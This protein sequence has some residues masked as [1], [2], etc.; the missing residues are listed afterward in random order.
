MVMIPKFLQK[1]VVIQSHTILTILLTLVAHF[2]ALSPAYSA[3]SCHHLFDKEPESASVHISSGMG[4]GVREINQTRSVESGASLIWLQKVSDWTAAWD[5]ADISGDSRWGYRFLGAKA[6]MFGF[7][8]RV[9]SHEEHYS[10]PTIA[11][12]NWAIEHFN[13]SHPDNAIPLRLKSVTQLSSTKDFLSDFTDGLI[14]VGTSIARTYLHD[15]NYHYIVA[16][17][18][19]PKLIE[20]W[21]RRAK[22]VLDVVD[23]VSD[24]FQTSPV[25]IQNLPHILAQMAARVDQ[26]GNLIPLLQHASNHDTDAKIFAQLLAKQIT[27]GSDRDFITEIVDA[28]AQYM[29]TLYYYSFRGEITKD[30]NMKIRKSYEYTNNPER[31]YFRDVVAQVLNEPRFQNRLKSDPVMENAKRSLDLFIENND[32]SALAPLF[33]T[34]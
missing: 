16:I 21:K 34:N 13:I 23:A 31:V 9:V 4:S 22:L 24:Q 20:S 14:P 30:E 17:L 6:S 26:T 5:T 29:P 1:T 2:T 27:S 7:Q 18:V 28:A 11:H 33:R 8:R 25:I 3:G 10:V 12:G 32:P 19:R 15:M